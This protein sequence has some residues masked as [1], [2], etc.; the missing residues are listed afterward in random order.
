VQIKPGPLPGCFCVR[1][2]RFED[3]R[4][5]FVKTF[6]Q[7]VYAAAGITLDMHEEFYSVSQKNVIRGMHFQLPPHDHEKMVYCV[8]GTV[9]DVLLDLRRGAG[10]GTVRSLTLSAENGVLLFI[11]RGVAHGFESL[12]NDSIL[13]YKTAT[14]HS[15]MHDCGIRWNSFGYQW[16]TSSPVLSDRDRR[17]PHLD[18]FL[19]PF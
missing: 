17:H 2:K 14:E 11:A 4:G 1:L 16:K 18:E 5:V 15:P 3:I 10:Y 9:G 6:S 7:T 8:S 12:T 13:I 19:S